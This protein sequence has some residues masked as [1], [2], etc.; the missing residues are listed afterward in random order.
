LEDVWLR[1]HCGPVPAQGALLDAGFVR[2]LGGYS[3]V[4]E[5][6]R[7]FREAPTEEVLDRCLYHDIRSYLPHL[8]QMEDRLSMAVSLE[9]RLPLLD[10]RVVELLATIPPELKVKGLRPKRL[11]GEI[12]GGVIPD[13]IRQR[14][15]KIPFAVPV[16]RWFAR[17][18][19]GLIDAVLRSPQ[20]LDRG[21]IDPDWLRDS[22]L[23]S[24]TIWALLN[25][26]LWFRV[27]I[28]RDPAWSA[29]SLEISSPAPR[30]VSSRGRRIRSSLLGRR[31]PAH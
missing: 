17:E 24:S 10:Y 16:K 22:A 26:E 11:L 14:R 13:S 19:Q 31:K 1:L 7:P 3:P 25:L 29:R 5:Y 15:D 21:V 9:S 12:A 2:R 23:T 20:S 8:L 30:P 6:L 27:F 4:E 28:D 18:L